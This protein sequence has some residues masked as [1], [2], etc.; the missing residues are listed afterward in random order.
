MSKHLPTLFVIL[1]S[2]SLGYFIYQHLQMQAVIAEYDEMKGEYLYQQKVERERLIHE[3][4]NDIDEEISDAGKHV[5]E[6]LIDTLRY[7]RAGMDTIFEQ[8]IISDSLID[9]WELELEKIYNAN[10]PDYIEPDTLDFQSS[11]KEYQLVIN[12]KWMLQTQFHM[13]LYL[14]NGRLGVGCRWGLYKALLEIQEQE[15]RG[16]STVFRLGISHNGRAEGLVTYWYYPD[17][18]WKIDKG[19]VINEAKKVHC[20]VDNEQLKEGVKLSYKVRR[21]TGGYEIYHKNIQRVDGNI[22]VQNDY[23][24]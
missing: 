18:E 3:M 20:K 8:E 10:L 24:D 9:F 13:V 22:V 5:N 4:L 19:R 6:G 16:D 2:S 17:T 15:D 14:L 1:L 21:I 12:R 11:A 23:S 7:L